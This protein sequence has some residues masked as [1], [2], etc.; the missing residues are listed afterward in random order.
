MMRR[1]AVYFSHS[2]CPS[3]APGTTPRTAGLPPCPGHQ[4]RLALRRGACSLSGEGGVTRRRWGRS[5]GPR[6]MRA[7]SAWSNS[8]R[9]CVYHRSGAGGVV[10]QAD[11]DGRS[12]RSTLYCS[13]MSRR[14][15]S[16]VDVS[17]TNR[18][19]DAVLFSSSTDLQLLTETGCCRQRSYHTSYQCHLLPV[20]RP[21][22]TLRPRGHNYALPVCY[23]MLHKKSFIVNCLYRP[24]F[25]VL[26]ERHCII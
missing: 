21:L 7:G 11:G 9:R 13:M 6:Q 2:A 12:A 14:L 18:R 25:P 1:P 19:L 24:S 16:L 23:S 3:A 17:R 5:L 8:R 26:L 22:D 4:R 10:L 20:S 15:H